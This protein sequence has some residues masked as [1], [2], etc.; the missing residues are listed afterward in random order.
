MDEDRQRDSISRRR[1]YGL[2]MRSELW[3]GTIGARRA[4]TVSMI[5]VL[6]IPWR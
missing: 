6:S 5:S 3:T 1:S 2:Q 4:W